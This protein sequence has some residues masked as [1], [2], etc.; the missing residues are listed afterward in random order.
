[1][2]YPK[3]RIMLLALLLTIS[4]YATAENC[5]DQNIAGLHYDFY[6]NAAMPSKDDDDNYLY[7]PGSGYFTGE[8]NLDKLTSTISAADGYFFQWANRCHDIDSTHC[9]A[10]NGNVKGN[11]PEHSYNGVD[12]RFF[13]STHI[14][15]NMCTLAQAYRLVGTDD[16]DIQAL[17]S[18]WGFTALFS[19]S[20]LDQHLAT[21]NKFEDVCYI[22][23]SDLSQDVKGIVLD[24]EVQ[25]NRHVNTTTNFLTRYSSYVQQRGLKSVLWTNPPNAGGWLK[26]GF[27]GGPSGNAQLVFD[28]M[29]AVALFAHSAT[30][31]VISE[32]YDQSRLYLP[33][34]VD[35]NKWVNRQKFYVIV[36]LG[37]FSLAKSK[38]VYDFVLDKK[39]KGVAIWNNYAEYSRTDC[40]SPTYQM[41]K[42]LAHGDCSPPS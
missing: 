4:N 21:N 12:H 37:G 24:Y 17:S 39:H 36:G 14:K 29:D 11:L 7:Y 32:L 30:T 35:Y 38:D 25:D 23:G 2:K 27:T 33:S 34:N 1:M 3:F 42:C 40:T 13:F 8:A 6:R 5:L 31:N 22:Y 19:E 9:G 18:T 10:P 20:E 28:E 26:S 16:L 41:L 15:A